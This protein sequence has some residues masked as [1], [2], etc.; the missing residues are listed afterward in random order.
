MEK[1]IS[2]GKEF[3]ILLT[4]CFLVFAAKCYCTTFQ[5]QRH[6]CMIEGLESCSE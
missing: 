3:S 6:L 1:S 2:S 5:W 4:L